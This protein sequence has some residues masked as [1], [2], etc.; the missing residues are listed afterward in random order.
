MAKDLMRQHLRR[1]LKTLSGLTGAN[2][3]FFD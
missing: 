1:V 3:D 2:R